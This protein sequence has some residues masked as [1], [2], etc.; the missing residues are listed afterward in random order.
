MVEGAVEG[1]VNHLI[2]K[3]FDCGGMRSRGQRA[4]ALLLVKLIE[5]NK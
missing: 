3:R 5:L 4:E 2:A 1:A